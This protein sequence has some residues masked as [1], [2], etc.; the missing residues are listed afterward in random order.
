MSTFTIVSYL[1][2]R[3][4][5]LH[6][7]LLTRRVVSHCSYVFSF[8]ILALLPPFDANSAPS[9]HD[10]EQRLAQ[11]RSQLENVSEERQQLEHMRGQAVRRL[12]EADARVA[13]SVRALNQA[14]HAV[15]QQ[16]KALEQT[17][18]A[19]RMLQQ[20][21]EVQRRA[22]SSLIQEAY[23]LGPN[24]PLQLLFSH[25]SIASSNRVLMY[26]AYFQA[27]LHRCL[28]KLS[29]QV[30]VVASNQIE[31][32]RQQHT[33]VQAEQKYLLD[34]ENLQRDR[35]SQANA[36]TALDVQYQ[37]KR[38]HEKAL[39][40]DALALEHVLLDLRQQARQRERER[41]KAA[42]ASAF[43]AND[44]SMGAVV[45]LP[46][47]GGGAWP[48]AGNLRVGYGAALP[49]G[50]QSKGLLIKAPYDTP[51]VAVADGTVAFADWMTGYGMIMIIDHGNGYMSLY[52]H[53]ETL[54]QAVGAAVRR[55]DV[56][57]KV[58]NSGGLKDAGLYFELRKH[59]QPIDP[60]K[61]LN[62]G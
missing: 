55:G 60:V 40:Q 28:D 38:I 15:E 32:D 3:L 47:V 7:S 53:N 18:R 39:S 5:Y 24:V 46:P 1:A 57:A 58:G 31:M 43:H 49:N 34:V 27:A 51:V 29:H 45:S 42:S 4:F 22:L 48:V 44:P 25:E 35:R 12:R 13:D 23:A 8:A 41:K 50:R 20:Q 59:G 61:W 10:T 37:N 36:V 56:I 26:A 19:Q 21:L 62:H 52:A 11:T 9:Q 17:R 2:D 14:Q 6:S 16:Q 33:L 30:A 54:V